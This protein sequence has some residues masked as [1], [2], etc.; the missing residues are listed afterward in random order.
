VDQVLT[1]LIPLSVLLIFAIGAAFWWSVSSGQFD[2]LEGPAH[3]IIADDDNPF[4]PGQRGPAPRPVSSAITK[5][6]GHGRGRNR[7]PEEPST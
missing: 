1:L 5:T 4:D 2:D 6:L 7:K 3:R